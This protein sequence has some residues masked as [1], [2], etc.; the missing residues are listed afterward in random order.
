MGAAPNTGWCK[1]LNA[2]TASSRLATPSA[3]DQIK[4]RGLAYSFLRRSVA[5]SCSSASRFQIC[6]ISKRE[7]LL[8]LPAGKLFAIL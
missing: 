5:R 3:A 1:V 6:A 7:A 2:A 4:K 8:S